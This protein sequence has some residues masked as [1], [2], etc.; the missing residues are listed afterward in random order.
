MITSIFKNFSLYFEMRKPI[1]LTREGNRVAYTWNGK[2]YTHMYEEESMSPRLFEYANDHILHSLRVHMQ[3]LQFSGSLTWK[4]L[5]GVSEPCYIPKDAI[6][7]KPFELY[8][9]EKDVT[10]YYD[11]GI[12]MMYLEY[13]IQEWG[14]EHG[15]AMIV[16][17]IC[18]THRCHRG[19]HMVMERLEYAS[20][21]KKCFQQPL[22][23]VCTHDP[24]CLRQ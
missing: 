13:G 11:L 10:Y 2:C 12:A 7:R 15:P 21:R 19:D 20:S 1:L 16:S 8:H 9:R 24:K 18:G 22:Y 23:T 17:Y 4:Q 3:Q 5:D 14:D 6:Y